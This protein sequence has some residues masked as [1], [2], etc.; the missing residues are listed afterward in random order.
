MICKDF[1]EQQPTSR[2][3]RS[4]RLRSAPAALAILALASAG[5][6]PLSVPVDGRPFALPLT[7]VDAG[8]SLEFGGG[9]DQRVL[10][11]ADLVSWGAP[12]EPAGPTRLVLADGGQLVASIKEADRERITVDSALFGELQIPLELLAGVILNAPAGAERADRLLMAVRRA[13]GTTDRL[14]LENGDEL[15][16]S[17]RAIQSSAS[18]GGGAV[19]LETEA[20]PVEAAMDRVEAVILNP[21]VQAKPAAPALHAL[22]GLADG[23]LL[24]VHS[25]S[26]EASG[27]DEGTA[28]ITLAGELTW[29][30]PASAVV[31]LQTLG[32]R[33]RYLSDLAP[34]GYR[35][36]S[37]L[38]SPLEPWELA[39]DA[40]VGGRPLRARGRLYPKGL[41]MH[42]ASRVSYELT[43][44]DRRFEALLAIDDEAGAQ[45]SVVFRVYVDNEQRYASPVVRGGDA[46]VP[47]TVDVRGG[48]RLSLIVDFGER[49]DQND[50][51]DWLDARLVR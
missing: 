47:I 3:E 29:Q 40:S 50:R 15:A 31:Y 2:G 17:L 36:I 38:D 48:K 32:G 30:A 42:S 8:W 5:A 27:G 10:D 20:G 26:M 23:S 37:Y 39:R 46:V 13:E 45:G 21:A 41:G 49:G 6:A 28:W 25:M 22:V 4:G 33:A 11:A 43:P 35:Q 24:R 18:R 1:G 14:L 44:E 34:S 51:A 16:G 12:V 9:A 7:S 19:K